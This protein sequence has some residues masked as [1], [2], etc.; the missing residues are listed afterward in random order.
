MSDFWDDTA[1]ERVGDAQLRANVTDRWSVNG[2]PNGGYLMSIAARALREVLSHEDPLTIT[3]HYV[4]K[5]MVGPAYLFVE[6]IREG[7]TVSTAALRLVQE[8]RE[9]ARFTASYGN[10]AETSGESWVGDTPPVI[11]SE[12]CL[13][14]PRF[15]AIHERVE[16]LFSPTTADWLRGKSIDRMAHELIAFFRD[17]TEP[18]VM[19]LPFFAD[20]VPPTTFTKFGAVGW[21]PTLELTVHM[22]A[23]P[24]PG[25][26]TARFQTRYLI[27]G[28]MEEDGEIWD[29]SG[30]LVA[31]SRQ[32]AKYRGGNL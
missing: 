28:L 2:I 18:D 15:L 9:R 13:T 4:E 31:L 24:A 16:L 20:C 10:L 29:S 11:Q 17:G 5:S 8:G 12:K 7:N 25:R 6:V 23:K 32:L 14:S 3:G 21:V 22:R 30:Q 1:V 27:N 26:L 19:S